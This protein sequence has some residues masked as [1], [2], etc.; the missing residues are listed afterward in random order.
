MKK[1][2]RKDITFTINF[3]KED[4]FSGEN[5]THLLLLCKAYDVKESK[6]KKKGEI[7][8]I[9]NDKILNCDSMPCSDELQE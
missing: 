2:K 9:L 6:Q 4:Q 3:C 5:V 7:S 8:N 1:S